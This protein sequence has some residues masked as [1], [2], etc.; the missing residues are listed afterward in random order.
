MA[1]FS[2]VPTFDAEGVAGAERVPTLTTAADIGI[3][4]LD[5]F[6]EP[7]LDVTPAAQ[8]RE[9][10]EQAPRFR[11]WFRSTGVATAFHSRSLI[12]LPYLKR[13]GLY[14]ACTV[15]VPYVWFTNRMFIVQWKDEA[16]GRTRTLLAEPCDYELGIETPYFREE[17]DKLAGVS[18]NLADHMSTSHGHVTEIIA[19]A[20]LRPEDIDYIS[21]DH[22]HTQDIRR[23]VGTN[24]PAPD[25][26]YGDRP[27]PPAFPNAKLLVHERELEHVQDVHPFQARFH[28]SGTYHDIRTDNIVTLHGDVLLGP[29][30]ALI[31]TP[32]H[33]LG[34]HSLVVNT[35]RGIY[36]SS[37]NGIAAECYAPEHSKIPGVAKWADKW[38]FEVLMNFNTPEFA[39]WQYNSMVKEKLIADPV[40][41][42]P[43]FPQVAPSSEM[44][45]H[46]MAPGLRPT[47]T[48]GELSLGTVVRPTAWS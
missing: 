11:E 26:G 27:V 22:L 18:R 3:T 16:T 47:F 9:I 44:T 24:S 39:S 34:N 29:G 5:W 25:L 41:S 7:D 36:C 48:H 28:Q 1:P 21:F 19:D 8:L 37:E 4:T 35:D 17:Y 38:G 46:P 23:I 31:C 2:N 14:E 6:D 15:P 45:T 30:V 12:S 43:Q 20:G 10:R 42:H 33:T 40:P 13:Y 32:G